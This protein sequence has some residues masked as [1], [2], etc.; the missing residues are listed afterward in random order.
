MR[1]KFSVNELAEFGRLADEI[2]VAARDIARK[3]NPRVP[4]YEPWAF[5]LYVGGSTV[6]I[7]WRIGC[8]CDDDEFDVRYEWFDMTDEELDELIIEEQKRKER[9]EK[10]KELDKLRV[11]FIFQ[12]CYSLHDYY[13]TEHNFNIIKLDV[14]DVAINNT[15]EQAKQEEQTKE[16]V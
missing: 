3:F 15:E 14:D 6:T 11:D 1:T 5:D 9:L 16:I 2:K 10:Y 7:K 13:I 8:D 4:K 12:K